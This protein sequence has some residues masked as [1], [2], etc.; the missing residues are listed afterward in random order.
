[1]A[2]TVVGVL[3]GGTSSEYDL[4][5]KTG[6]SILNALPEDA[7]DARDI[8]I[9]RAGQWH[10]RGFPVAPA[11]ALQ[12]LDVVVNALHG[13]IGED[14][15]VQRVL[16]SVGVPYTGSSAVASALALHKARAGEV[17]QR[18]GIRMPQGI[19]FTASHEEDTG[20][21][22]RHTFAKFGPPYIVKPALEGASHGIMIAASIA[23]LPHVLA[24]ILDEYHSA[25][26][27][28]FI[29]GEEATVGVLE[30]FRSEPLYAFPP[31]HVLLPDD[32]PFFQVHHHR[33]GTH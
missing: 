2:R 14:G 28:E 15:T 23:D 9:D 7:Y 30:D 6:A 20:V 22:A 1:M 31:V 33:E 19:S 26:V 3:R 16:D 5:L 10:A 12:Q 29:E 17:L 18:A 24:E 4:S 21:M 13:G 25:I 8:F 11:R 27:Q 32:A